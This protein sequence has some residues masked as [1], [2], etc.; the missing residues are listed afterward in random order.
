MPADSY[1]SCFAKGCFRKSLRDRGERLPVLWQHN[2]NAPIGR[3]VT[4]KEDATG[5]AVDVH[6]IDDGAEGSTA[7]KRL[8]G[9]VPLGLSFG[10]QTVKD[11][12]ADD[13]DEIDL[14]Q[15]GSGRTRDIRVS[16]SS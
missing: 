9:G 5:L 4:I 14:S 13:E 6:L 7:L 12:S 15:L 11:R 1:L 8:R 2:P 10:F 3:H 16:A